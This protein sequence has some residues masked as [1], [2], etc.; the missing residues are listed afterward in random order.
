MHIATVKADRRRWLQAT[1]LL[2]TA[3]QGGLFV[4]SFAG[5]QAVVAPQKTLRV[6]CYN[7]HHG[8]GTDAQVNLPRQ[9]E[10]I[11]R[12]QP[13]LVA[14]QEVDDRTERTGRVDQTGELA[15]LTG[16]QG[17][18]ARQID[19]EGGR[20][21]QAILSRAPLSDI[22]VHWLPGMPPREQRIAAAVDVTVDGQPLTFV[23]THLHHQNGEF[24]EQQAARLN[25][26]FAD[27]QHP[28]I[29]AGDLNAEPDSRP[30]QILREQ[31]SVASAQQ[32][33]RTFPAAEPTKQIDFVLY[34][35]AE[36]LRV[37][38]AEV[39]PEP[40]ASDHRPLLVVLEWQPE[41]R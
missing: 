32:P 35:P 3:G 10:V 38:S 41:R 4:R 29:L 22:S 5:A 2:C 26:L 37:L 11:R 28:V 12:V 15:R 21:G 25:T 31:W 1:A 23:T 7:I 19:Y 20:Y 39:L 27:A 18:F 9:A 30:L 16:L 6:L 13:D 24:R 8:E 40:V 36:R 34:R 33:L 14:L 17:R